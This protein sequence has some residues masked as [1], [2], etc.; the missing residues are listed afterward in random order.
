MSHLHND[1]EHRKS[2]T[3]VS[4]SPKYEDGTPIKIGQKVSII[5]LENIEYTEVSPY[6]THPYTKKRNPHPDVVART[7]KFYSTNNAE[8]KNGT[9]TNIEYDPEYSVSKIARE[10]EV[11]LDDGEVKTFKPEVYFF[12]IKKKPSLL[13]RFSNYFTRSTRS[14]RPTISRPT[15]SRSS[16]RS[17][18]R[19]SSADK[20]LTGGKKSRSKKSR[21]NRRKSKNLY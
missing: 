1:Y 6:Y 7:T 12:M 16:T 2:K 18:T 11:T 4:D 13:N 15:R 3:E 20:S 14:T 17:S 19:S 9:L 21:K 5:P 8:F 10:Y